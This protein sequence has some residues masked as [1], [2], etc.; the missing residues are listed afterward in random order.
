MASEAVQIYAGLGYTTETRV[1]R[2]W[3]DLRGHEIAGGTNEIM[4]H[5]TG[6]QLAKKYAK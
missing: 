2:I 5:I 4:V 6:R 3:I 1:G